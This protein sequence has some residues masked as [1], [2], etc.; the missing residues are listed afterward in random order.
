MKKT[1]SKSSRS[2]G[3]GRRGRADKPLELER[4][5]QEL[6]HQHD[7]MK[8]DWMSLAAQLGIG[9]REKSAYH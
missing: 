2:R 6:E 3:P 7:R 8:S 1:S 9:G 4:G 5:W